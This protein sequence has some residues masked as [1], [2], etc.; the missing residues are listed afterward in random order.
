[1]Q[2]SMDAGKTVFV[3]TD[4]WTGGTAP[5][6]AEM[7]VFTKIGPAY[8]QADLAGT[9]NLNSIASGSDAPW[10]MRALLTIDNTGSLFWFWVVRE[11]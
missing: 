6:T 7:Y 2:C 5:G 11:R 3:C 9:W 10:W 8:A 1:M 4:T